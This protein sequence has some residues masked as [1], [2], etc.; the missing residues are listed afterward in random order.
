MMKWGTLTAGPG[1]SKIARENGEIEDGRQKR[2]R[3][4][5]LFFNDNLI[6]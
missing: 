4:L 6:K 2:I 5:W 1:S 3:L